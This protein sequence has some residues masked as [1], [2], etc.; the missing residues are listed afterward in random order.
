MNC[1]FTQAR[2]ASLTSAPA[3]LAEVRPRAS[4]GGLP[5]WRAPPIPKGA[6]DGPLHRRSNVSRSQLQ[7][8][9]PFR[10][11][12]VGG[13]AAG[14]EGHDRFDKAVR[15]GVVDGRLPG[16]VSRVGVGPCSQQRRDGSHLPRT[17]CPMQWRAALGIARVHRRTLRGEGLDDGGSASVQMHH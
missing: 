1:V 15:G 4:A 2:A 11:A 6:L 13:R 5:S 14:D 7:R 17:R 10:V 3:R 9:P 16:L 12:R 8:H